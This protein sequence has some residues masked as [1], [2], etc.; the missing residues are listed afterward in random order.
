MGIRKAEHTGNP[1]SQP[2]RAA[3]QPGRAVSQNERKRQV[4]RAALT[5]I[6]PLLVPEVVVGVGTGSTANHF[7]DA[8]ATVTVKGS[9]RTVASS[10]AT[11]ERLMSHGIVVVDLNDVE[12]VAV[13]VDGADEVTPSR[14][15]I[16][17]GGGALTREKIIAGSA[18]RFVCIV[19]D[20]KLVDVLGA[21]P[22]PVEVIPLA[23]RM[24]AGKLRELGGEPRRR[25]GFV[26][27]NG[28]EI[29]DV[30]GL[31]IAEPVRL[32]ARVNNIPGVVDNGIFA[33]ATRPHTV[34]IGGPR[35]VRLLE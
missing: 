3:P 12:S 7:I 33:I 19:D 18:E 5:L 16:K 20:S 10:V 14:A 11:A 34:L 9:I 6:E 2:G 28:N 30:H 23:R 31:A 24:V 15:L 26:T 27:D 21:F 22:L 29:L 13:Y 35:G 17:G 25:A 1:A 8:L 4:A 32:E